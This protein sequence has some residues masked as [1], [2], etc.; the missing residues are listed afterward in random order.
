MGSIIDKAINMVSLFARSKNTSISKNYTHDYFMI[1]D[2]LHLQ[3][4]YINILKNSIESIDSNGEITILAI[5]KNKEI[6]IMIKDN[7]NG[8]PKENL[9]HVIDPFFSTKHRTGNFGLGLSYCYSVMQHGG[10]LEIMSEEGNGTTVILNFPARRVVAQRNTQGYPL[11]Y[12]WL[13]RTESSVCCWESNHRGFLTVS[14][15]QGACPRIDCSDEF[16]VLGSDLVHGSN[17]LPKKLL[18]RVYVG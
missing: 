5:R 2:G 11:S 14:D 12:Q 7:G 4:T 1:C 18:K 3:E 17:L 15:I 13:S 10:S 9:A 6:S 8:I 16:P